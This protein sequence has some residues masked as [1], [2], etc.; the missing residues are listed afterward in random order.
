M[1]GTPR[2]APEC[3]RAPRDR[4]KR[5]AEK[6]EA[7][8][9]GARDNAAFYHAAQLTHDFGLSDD[10]AWPILAAWNARNTPP[11]GDRELRR[12]LASGRKNGKKP[13]GSKAVDPPANGQ[14][15]NSTNPNT[16]P[17]PI[18]LL[19]APPVQAFPTGVLTPALDQFIQEASA[20]L[21]CPPDYLGVPVLTLAGAAI[22][23]A[24]CL[25]IFYL[26]AW[27][28]GAIHQE[29]RNH[30]DDPL[31]VRYPFLAI[32]GGMPP[33]LLAEFGNHQVR[34]GFLDRF[35]FCYPE[36]WPAQGEDWKCL[37]KATRDLWTNCVEGL[38][39]LAMIEEAEQG[40]RPRFL[41][42]TDA[43]R[44]RWQTFTEELAADQ[45]R[46]DFLEYLQGAWAKME[47]YGARI[48]LIVH[49]LRHLE[50]GDLEEDVDGESVDRAARL[51]AYFQSQA[52][53]VYHALGVSK[54]LAG[55][56]VIERWLRSHP[57]VSDFR[58]ARLYGEHLRRHFKTPAAMEKP[59]ALLEE[60]HYIRRRKVDGM[61]SAC[62]GRP[63][64]TAFDVNPHW[65]R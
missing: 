44:L 63:R 33:D 9:E 41:Q 26:S 36:P 22:G 2:P 39:K 51:I 19:T 25:A 6:W 30:Q 60:H 32:T 27:S 17:V 5:Y 56:K 7:V 15:T 59:L 42:L 45:N 40:P 49:A 52:R 64:A 8:P 20:A 31:V 18:P 14:A 58:Q 29:R 55:A 11:L 54:A 12:C 47:G 53:K 43:G 35:L 1:N 38:W 3:I 37:T 62:N 13:T 21:H 24:R 4:A 48:S 28:G 34:D 16:W 23:A 57:D 50:D 65:A 61:P 10:E 46:V